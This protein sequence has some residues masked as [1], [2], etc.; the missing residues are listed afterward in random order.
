[1]QI[2]GKSH[3]YV[4]SVPSIFNTLANLRI[5]LFEEP[6]KCNLCKNLIEHLKSAGEKP[7]VC[8]E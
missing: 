2:T 1:M 8:N 3:Q 6:S 7:S 5:F 4:I